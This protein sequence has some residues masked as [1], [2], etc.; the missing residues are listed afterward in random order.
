[1]RRRVKAFDFSAADAT[2]DRNALIGI[3][4]EYQAWVAAE[5][6]S[7]FAVSTQS[8]VGMD[9][10]AYVLSMIDKIVG[11]PPPRGIFY[12]VRVDGM[13]AGM[14]GLRRLD[15]SV[16]EIKR[17]YV[18]PSLRGHGLGRAMVQRL[19]AD[20]RAFG[21]TKVR[22]DSAPFMRSAQHIYEASGFIDREPYEGVEVPAALH[23]TW[24][25]MERDV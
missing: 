16:A 6:D 9:V 1:L 17:V 24:R 11:E 20:A 23:A 4:T 5:V 3:N 2:A 14:G 7:F 25:F 19:L 12:L 10:P 22:L 21:Y 8:L 13:L 18:R 15:E